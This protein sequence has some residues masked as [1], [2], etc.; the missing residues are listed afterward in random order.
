MECN[1]SQGDASML[2]TYEHPNSYRGTVE[3][4]K[5]ETVLLASG[6]FLNNH[7]MAQHQYHTAY[8]Q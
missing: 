3:T 6:F 4:G 8:A 5:K 2:S 7:Q 1:T